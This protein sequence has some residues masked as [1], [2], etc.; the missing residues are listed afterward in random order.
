MPK[1]FAPQDLDCPDPDGCPVAAQLPPLRTVSLSRGPAWYRVYDA[2]WGYDEHNPG[3][4]DTRFSPIDD[5]KNGQRLPSM[6][7]AQTPT[8]ALLETVFHSVHQSSPRLI[9]ER[10]LRGKHLACV[11]VPARAVLADLRDPELDRL[12]RAR[13]ATVATAAEH[14]PCTRRLAISALRRKNVQGLIWHSRQAELAGHDPVEVTVLYGEPRYSS[15]RGS[16]TLFG[17]GTSS[18]YDGPG[19]V[20]VE[21][22]AESL[23][24]V[25]ERED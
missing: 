20:L 14:Y 6:Y 3:H 13:A 25:I 24:A 18:L 5:P 11:R 19:R 4:G 16:W 2:I 7:L 15:E 22:V 23:E 9:Y 10:D 8:A 21:E 12:G 1:P 17:S